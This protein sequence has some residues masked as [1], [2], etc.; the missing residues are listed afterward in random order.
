[1]EIK[2]EFKE[3]I[4]KSKYSIII[5]LFFIIFA[6]GQRLISNS[7]SIDTEVYMYNIEN[8][9]NWD[10]WN[11]LSRWSAV[12][13]NKAL[14]IKMFPI[15]AT[16][17][18]TLIIMFLYSIAFNFL[19]Y[20]NLKESYKDTFTKYQFVFPI[21]FL[22]NPIFAEQYNFIH[23]N[24]SIA[25]GILMIPMSLLLFNN[26]ENG[27]SKFKRVESYILG[28]LLAVLGFGVY[29][30]IILL[31]I[32][33]VVSC[34]ILKIL[35]EN[36][37]CWK[38]LLKQILLFG[39]IVLIYY[40]IS[41]MTGPK[42]SYLQIVWFKDGFKICARNISYVIKDV[43]KCYGIYYN[44]GYVIALIGIIVMTVYLIKT[45]K[46]KVGL[47]ISILALIMAP[48]Y[49]MFVTGVNQFY[50]TQFN[51]SYA[52]GFMLLLTII[53]LFSEA[54]RNDLLNLAKCIIVVLTVVI[55]YRQSYI[56][57]NLFNTADIIYKG[58]VKLA[59]KLIGRIEEQ[60]WYDANKDYTLIFIGTYSNI[61]QSAYIKGEIIG[62]SFFD[63]GKDDSAGISG[64]AN[65]FLTLIGYK[66]RIPTTEEYENAKTY[67]AN[68][69]L[70][71]WPNAQSILLMNDNTIVVK[72]S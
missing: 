70:K 32:A 59:D 53:V 72:L 66:Y 23:Q 39:I 5:I 1:M 28:I 35:K 54:K 47:I 68:R 57:A 27:A 65:M 61:P 25:L 10:W 63:F 11:S 71:A 4:K 69:Q 29:Q 19:F 42:G 51:Y 58:D 13:I 8:N 62:D 41:K 9:V 40:V 44:I 3:F 7:F 30:S 21:I 24:V 45:R 17:C 33:T 67:V 46:M 52:S 18:L 64:R 48:F 20:I 2:K 22:T 15:Y 43:L 56:T 14:E 26:A 16:N 31:Y 60:D 6:F 49:I 50:R 36:D 38:Y 37:N 12:W 55:A 34:Y